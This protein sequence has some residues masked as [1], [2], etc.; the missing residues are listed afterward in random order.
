MPSARRQS[1]ALHPASLK[2]VGPP[3]FWQ[4]G[5]QNLDFIA[6]EPAGSVADVG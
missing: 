1:E 4:R 6:E 3:G 2:S 5:E